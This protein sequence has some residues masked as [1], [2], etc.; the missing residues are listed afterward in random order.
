M[1]KEE[2]LAI[3]EAKSEDKNHDF[4]MAH[5]I[6]DNA[7]MEYLESIGHKDIVEAFENVGRW[8]A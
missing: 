1:N 5:G 7:V 8:Y 2:L 6:A 3:L 4:E